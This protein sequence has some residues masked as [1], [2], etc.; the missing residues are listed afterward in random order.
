M[1]RI[2]RLTIVVP[3]TDPAHATQLAREVAARL[4]TELAGKKPD[5]AARAVERQFAGGTR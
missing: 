1:T 3:H 4:A 5:Q 2:E